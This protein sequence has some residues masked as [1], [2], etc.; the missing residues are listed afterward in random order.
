MTA[1]SHS[2]VAHPPARAQIAHLYMNVYWYICSLVLLTFKFSCSDI[3][4]D[5]SVLLDHIKCFF[6]AFLYEPNSQHV[7]LAWSPVIYPYQ[8]QQYAI[9]DALNSIYSL[10]P[11]QQLSNFVIQ[12]FDRQLKCVRL[13]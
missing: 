12:H 10:S 5:L 11:H 8:H 7:V 3:N 13:R 6:V 1:K 2:E 9:A 4:F